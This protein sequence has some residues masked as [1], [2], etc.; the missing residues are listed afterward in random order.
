MGCMVLVVLK[1]QMA[2]QS[3]AQMVIVVNMV[4]MV[5]VMMENMVHM[6]QVMMENKVQ[7]VIVESM[8][9]MD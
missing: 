9:P 1:A 5:Q 3:M 6:V 7:M 2:L 8:V 4:H